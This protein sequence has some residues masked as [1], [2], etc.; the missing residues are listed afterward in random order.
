[1]SR[2]TYRRLAPA[3]RVAEV[4][5]GEG[6]SIRL[7][8]WALFV[9]RTMLLQ[10]AVFVLLLAWVVHTVRNEPPSPFETD[11]ADRFP[12]VIWDAVAGKMRVV[13]LDA[14]RQLGKKGFPFELALGEERLVAVREQLRTMERSV[15]EGSWTG[16][17]VY[18]ASKDDWVGE[19]ACWMAKLEVEGRPP[20]R[21]QF[22][23]ECWPNDDIRRVS[24]YQ[25]DSG[26][27]HPTH[28]LAR[29]PGPTGAALTIFSIPA[30]FVGGLV[31]SLLWSLVEW[32][33]SR[34]AAAVSR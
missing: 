16:G 29:L 10:L 14:V 32:I 7:E 19:Q 13:T 1:M 21:Q 2:R 20:E 8:R 26:G 23:F 6:R 24:L 27:I 25:V 12:V 9:F 33:R 4:P 22:R 30:A 17:M 31:L 3:R 15:Q 18:E 28:Y 34:R 11:Q 5:A